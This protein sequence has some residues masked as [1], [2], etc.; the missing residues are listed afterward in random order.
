MTHVDCW[1]KPAARA[2]SSSLYLQGSN[3]YIPVIFNRCYSYVRFIEDTCKLIGRYL[4][5]G[6]ALHEA[7]AFSVE[8]TFQR[9][10]EGDI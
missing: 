5:L 8:G 7:V 10:K 2:K 4:L 6:M 1:F 9:A 3:G